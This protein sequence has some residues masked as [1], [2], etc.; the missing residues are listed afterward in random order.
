MKGS[1]IK[2]N[3]ALYKTQKKYQDTM[4]AFKNSLSHKNTTM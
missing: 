1:E 2:Q 4:K 3:E